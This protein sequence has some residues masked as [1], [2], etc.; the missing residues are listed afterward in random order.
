MRILPYLSLAAVIAALIGVAWFL[1]RSAE[2]AAEPAAEKIA[3]D[4]TAPPEIATVTA[5][6]DALTITLDTGHRVRY[7]GVRPP[8]VGRE[9]QCF[10][11]EALDA[12]EAIIGQRVRLETDPV[13]NKATDGAWIRYVYL[14]QGDV[15]PEPTP[16]PE[17][18]P[19]QEPEEASATNDEASETIEPVE[20]TPNPDNEEENTSEITTNTPPPEP[21][22]AEDIFINERMLEGGFAF[23][24]VA[25]NMTYGAQMLS[26][27]RFASA[28]GKGMWGQ[29]EITEKEEGRLYTNV[30]TDCVIKGDV[31][32]EQKRVYRTP[33]CEQYAN[34]VPITAD[35]DRW[36]CDEGHAQ[37]EG[38]QPASDCPATQ[39]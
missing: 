21:E 3:A 39:E 29:C 16:T 12:N 36:L 26:A 27:A 5:V 34:H 20:T 8:S 38:W 23:P 1:D 37:A 18:T 9:V 33:S 32:S 19:T 10:G 25:E 11:K 28:T 30:V 35:G 31:I 17:S 2:E 15:D 14:I 6:H 4:N 13:I 7:L 24:L 22:D